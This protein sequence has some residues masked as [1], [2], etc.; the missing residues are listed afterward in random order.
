MSYRD[1]VAKTQAYSAYFSFPL[2][3]QE[4]HYWL[5]TDHPVSSEVLAPYLSELSSQAKKLRQRLSQQTLEKVKLA[6]K[7][8]R[9]ARHLPCIELIALTGSIAVG[10]TRQTDDI[11]LLIITAPNTLWLVRPLFLFLLAIKFHRRHPGDNVL[12]IQDSFCP[13]L[14][15]DMSSLALPKNKRNL[16][17]AHEVLQIKPLYDRGGVYQS[18]L[19]ANHWTKRFLA[20]VYSALVPKRLSPAHIPSVYFVFAPFNVL[21]FFFQYLYMLPKIT[22]ERVGLH[23]AFFHKN[24]LSRALI[25]HLRHN[26]L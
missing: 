22:T 7:F 12:R 13:N 1:V 5:I 20:N 6:S 26:C 8:V 23:A 24:D 10:N 3:P 19:L 25:Q 2:T 16:Y 17:T 9:L 11:D 14:W 4:T 21:A 18:F 15:L